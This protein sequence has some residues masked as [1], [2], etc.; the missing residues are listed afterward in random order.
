V[1]GAPAI[2]FVLPHRL[3]KLG[4]IEG[5]NLV[6]DCVSA[7][8]R[9]DQCATAVPAIPRRIGRSRTAGAVAVQSI[10]PRIDPFFDLMTMQ[11]AR[12]R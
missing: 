10:N 9:M 5:R 2:V 1:P 6:I 12:F 3:A 4:W 7:A 8:G 11:E